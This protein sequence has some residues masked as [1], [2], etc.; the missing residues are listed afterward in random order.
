[1]RKLYAGEIQ[2]RGC[3]FCANMVV[4]W[5]YSVGF[6]RSNCTFRR[7][8]YRILDKHNSY[9]EFEKSEDCKKQFSP[10]YGGKKN[11]A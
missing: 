2:H 11:E 9:V 10:N 4:K 3:N 5:D 1:M 6:P 7:C 8:P